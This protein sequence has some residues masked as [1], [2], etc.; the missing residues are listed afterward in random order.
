LSMNGYPQCKRYVKM[1]MSSTGDMF[2]VKMH[3]TSA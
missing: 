1:Q 2:L 3:G